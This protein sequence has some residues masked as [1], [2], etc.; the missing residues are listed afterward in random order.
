MLKDFMITV[1]DKNGYTSKVMVTAFSLEQ[2][3]HA[4][5]YCHPEVDT[6]GL[7]CEEL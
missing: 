4:Y 5:I 3:C 1:V 6:M 7:S 2:A